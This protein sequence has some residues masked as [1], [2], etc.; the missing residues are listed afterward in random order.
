MHGFMTVMHYLLSIYFK[1]NLYMFLSRVASHH[2]EVLL[3]I[4]KNWCMSIVYVD[5][6]LAGF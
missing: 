4:Y 2:Q 3:C 6:L 5:S 1:I